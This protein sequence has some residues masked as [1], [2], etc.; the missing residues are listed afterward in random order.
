MSNCHSRGKLNAGVDRREQ[1]SV[2][3]ACF[4]LVVVS[5]LGDINFPILTPSTR[6]CRKLVVHIA[7]ARGRMFCFGL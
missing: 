3:R 4:S 7:S 2:G 5:T 6:S 1:D